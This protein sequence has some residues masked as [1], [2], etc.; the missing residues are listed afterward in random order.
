MIPFESLND[1]SIYDIE[2]FNQD[3]LLDYENWFNYVNTLDIFDQATLDQMKDSPILDMIKSYHDENWNNIMKAQKL[4][5]MI[6]CDNDEDRIDLM[7]GRKL[8][9]MSA[10][11]YDE[12]YNLFMKGSKLL[13]MSAC[14][15][16]ENRIDLMKGSKLL[17]MSA[18][19]N[20]ENYNLFN[21]MMNYKFIANLENNEF[22]ESM[23]NKHIG[24]VIDLGTFRKE[25]TKYFKDILSESTLGI[26]PSTG[27]FSNV[28]KDYDVDN[29]QF[30]NRRLLTTTNTLVLPTTYL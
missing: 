18:C 5:D 20:D 26:L 12:N 28:L 30:K 27:I 15:N 9:D 8:L 14:D 6:A 17:D 3:I 2:I 21:N 29:F 11:D 22:S 25:N 23:L 1:S 16:D 7:K 10:C 4:L 19:D 24:K 13:D